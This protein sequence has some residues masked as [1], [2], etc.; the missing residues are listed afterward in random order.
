MIYRHVNLQCESSKPSRLWQVDTNYVDI[1]DITYWQK[2]CSRASAALYVTAPKIKNIKQISRASSH[3]KV[4][5]K[6]SRTFI[7]AARPP[8]NSC[9]SQCFRHLG[10]GCPFFGTKWFFAPC[11]RCQR[12]GWMHFFLALPQILLLKV[13]HL[14]SS[15]PSSRSRT[16]CICQLWMTL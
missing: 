4:K 1:A 14:W 5:H 10:W 7:Q 9:L 16:S 12:C 13:F 8:P 2:Q 11:Q 15:P 3:I 6:L